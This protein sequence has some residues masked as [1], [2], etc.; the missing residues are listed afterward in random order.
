MCY[1]FD[2]NSGKVLGYAWNDISRR[3][4]VEL[5]FPKRSNVKQMWNLSLDDENP[6]W[7]KIQN[8]WSGTYMSDFMKDETV[9]TQWCKRFEFNY[10]KSSNIRRPQKIGEPN[11]S[12][13]LIGSRSI[14]KI[15]IFDLKPFLKSLYEDI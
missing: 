8:A 6:G 4:I 10:R 11:F 5:Q 1:I 7:M 15:P 14:P 12:L 13:F 9:L 3:N 2:K